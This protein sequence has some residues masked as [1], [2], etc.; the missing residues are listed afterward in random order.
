MH[1]LDE[2]KRQTL[3][4]LKK[5]TLGIRP[6]YVQPCAAG[7]PGALQIKIDRAQDVGTHSLL[8]GNVGESLFRVRLPADAILP[9]VGDPMWFK[10]VGSHTCFYNNGELV[11]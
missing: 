2:S 5:F 8:T 4:A 9:R 6:E 11:A 1:S 10:V 7:T 3:A